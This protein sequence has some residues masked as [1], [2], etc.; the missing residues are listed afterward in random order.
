MSSAMDFGAKTTAFEV[1]QTFSSRI[2]GKTALIT[3]VT[4]GSIGDATAR[5]FAHG[6]AETVVI[7]GR[8]NTKLSTARK[9]LTEAYPKTR[10]RPLNLDLSSLKAVQKAAEE[11]LVDKNVLQID[12]LVANAG[13]NTFDQPRI[14]T[15]DGIE[16]H[17]GANHLGHHLFVK[18]LLP[19]IRAAAAK[20]APGETRIVVV[21][22]NGS[23]TSP[24][25]FSDWNYVKASNDVPDDEKPN[26]GPY[27]ALCGLEPEP[28][29]FEANI[30]YGQSKTAN[31]LMAVHLNKLSAGEGIYSFSLHPGFVESNGVKDFIP[32]MSDT[33][34][35]LLNQIKTLEQGAATSLVAAVDPGLKPEGGVFLVD[36]Q[37]NREMC[38]SW[39]CDE[40][41]AEKLWQ[42]SEEILDSKL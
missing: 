18:Q 7:T 28:A 14:E 3:G 31:V 22:S 9:A 20:N 37:V 42:L 19:K 17:F 5:A 24:I 34:K 10:F 33:L 11:I 41:A 38:P 6:G 40:G 32:K 8:D 1:A 26:W 13:R 36:C 29:S 23:M 4:L 2:A 16:S 30:A 39:A 35:P 21:S 27:A 15:T 25:R 12:F